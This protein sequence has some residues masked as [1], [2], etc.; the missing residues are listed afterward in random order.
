MTEPYYRVYWGRNIDRSAFR[1]EH[2]KSESGDWTYASS[3]GYD[4][5][6]MDATAPRNA[7]TLEEC[8]GREG[9]S[10]PAVPTTNKTSTEEDTDKS[11]EAEVFR[12]EH[13]QVQDDEPGQTS[14]VP[15]S[16]VGQTGVGTQTDPAPSDYTPP[17]DGSKLIGHPELESWVI[18]SGSSADESSTSPAPVP[19]WWETTFRSIFSR[20]SKGE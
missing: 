10:N 20:G 17:G 4:Q 2:A 9:S 16:Q 1:V 7:D 15:F 8:G 3:C 19:N 5:T 13:R 6:S 14:L 11:H 12:T 18:A